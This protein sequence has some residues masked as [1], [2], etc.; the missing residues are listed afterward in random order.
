MKFTT[1]QLTRTALLLALCIASQFLKNTS[2]YITGPIINAILVITLLTV[3]LGAALVI[4]VITPVTAFFITGSLIMAGIPLM[5]PVIMCG[6]AILVLC[7]WIF[8]KK[9]RKKILLYTGMGVGCVLKAAFMWVM[10]SFVLFPLFGDNIA[11]YLPKPEAL[12]KVLA[13]AKVTFS[14]TQLITAVTG[15]VLAAIIMMPLK[16]YL[17]NED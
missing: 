15:C 3:N 14:M 1:K 13:T 11:G 17:K 10:T 9:S 12:P 7:T 2:V 4:A 6:N 16:K 8:M 5:F